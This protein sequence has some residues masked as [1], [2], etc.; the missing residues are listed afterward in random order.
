MS[1]RYTAGW[2]I[3]IYIYI[4][5]R[6]QREFDAYFDIPLSILIEAIGGLEEGM[7]HPVLRRTTVGH[8]PTAADSVKEIKIRCVLAADILYEARGTAG[9]RPTISRTEADKQIFEEVQKDIEKLGIK[10]LGSRPIAGWRTEVKN[11]SFG[12]L[13]HSS[14]SD[15]RK[16]SKL[17]FQV[18]GLN[19]ALGFLL[20]KITKV[21]LKKFR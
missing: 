21:P 17:M 15:L 7:L 19:A 2:S 20:E 12:G 13:L 6:F 5:Y 1:P 3:V 18:Y 16:M 11:Y 10:T 8:R 9:K 14:S 4:A